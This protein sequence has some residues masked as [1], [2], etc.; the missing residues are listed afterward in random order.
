VSAAAR[1]VGSATL[2]AM[3]ALLAALA[4]SP[5][6]AAAP[7]ADYVSLGSS[8]A[9]GPGI[10]PVES[11][12][13]GRSRENYARLLAAR[14][15]LTLTDVS[16]SGAT[17]AHILGAWNE[18]SP[19]VDAVGP[20]TRLVTITI[21]GNDVNYIGAIIAAS[22]R[23]LATRGQVAAERCPPERSS[24]P[25]WPA[26]ARQLDA[27]IAAVRARSP[28]AH[29]VLIDYLALLPATGGCAAVPLGAVDYRMARDRA[30]RLNR[31][32]AAAAARNAVMLEAASRLSRR[33]HAC[34]RAPWMTGMVDARG[35]I[36]RVP[37]H[38]NAQ[39]M[40]ALAQSL[41]TRLSPRLAPKRTGT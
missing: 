19:Q 26:L 37:Y 13:C 23:T 7:S 30:R 22:C 34:A 12:R 33:H 21:G 41:G 39:A 18:L 20:Q 25:D 17:T 31:A 27:V 11:G 40:R 16:C 2:H 10:E 29:I 3:T 4:L 35:T 5:A 28:G 14:L 1:R 38:P 36:V 24:P 32:I 9:A 6:R 8:F 15:R